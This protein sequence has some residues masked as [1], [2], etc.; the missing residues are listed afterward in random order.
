M[1]T[2]S[3]PHYKEAALKHYNALKL[4]YE[5]IIDC[6]NNGE[7][8]KCL[9]YDAYYIS[10]YIFEG[11]SVYVIFNNF[12][13]KENIEIPIGNFDDAFEEYMNE[14]NYEGI[15]P[16]NDDE[17]AQK[18]CRLLTNHK[19]NRY[20]RKCYTGESYS[21]VPFLDETEWHNVPYSINKWDA[22]KRYFCETDFNDC[23]LI[24]NEREIKKIIN[25]CD[26]YFTQILNK[27]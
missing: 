16:F 22:N 5:K 21:G 1:A 23:N 6:K 19:I 14:D 15:C 13:W 3:N 8:Y 26:T 24:V 4:M 2:T 17:E 27:K 25:F 10:G 11:V 9:V 20:T 12:K 18:F 7:D